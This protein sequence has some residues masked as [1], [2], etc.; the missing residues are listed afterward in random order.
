MPYIS[1]NA[2]V[3]ID[4]NTRQP[5]TAGELNYLLTQTCIRYLDEKKSYQ[6]YNDVIGALDACKME[7][8]RRV[9]VDYENAKINENGDVYV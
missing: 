7:F 5:A 8:Y 9:V 2:R 6:L 1:Q 3:A 4:W